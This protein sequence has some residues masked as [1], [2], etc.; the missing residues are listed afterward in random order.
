MSEKQFMSLI[1]RAKRLLAAAEPAVSGSGGHDKLLAAASALVN[2]FDFTDELALQLL[3]SDYNP[4]C[5]PPWREKDVQRKVR[6]AR[7]LG[8][9]KAPGY[10]IGRARNESLPAQGASY[11]KPVE[12]SKK[13]QEFSRKALQEMMVA[14]FA[15]DVSWLAEISPVDPREVSAQEFL[16]TIFQ[17]GENTLIFLNYFGQGDIGHVAGQPGESWWLAPR[18]GMKPTKCGDDFP[19]TAAEGAWFLPVPMDGK[20]YPTDR[21]DDAGNP[22]LSRRSG[23]SIVAYRHL[24]LES[25]EANETEWLNLLCQMPLPITALYTSGGRSIHALVKLD[26]DSKGQFDAF[27]ERFMPLISRLGGDP[28]AI[29]GLRLTRL[30]GVLREGGKDKSGKYQKYKKPALQRLLY[31][32]PRPEIRALKMMP[33]LRLIDTDSI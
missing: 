18:P 11:G 33:R 26:C 12:R 3:L 32:N 31:L 19:V 17:P 6:E 30:P 13:Y 25:D 8:G 20:W 1:E 4:R 15:P 9:T 14:G 21:V 16:D 23:R 28:R 7:K 27:R 2:G 29:S 10:L 22:I 24:V 5:V